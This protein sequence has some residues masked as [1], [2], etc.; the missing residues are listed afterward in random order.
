MD[1]RTYR[2][3]EQ[4][5]TWHLNEILENGKQMKWSLT[6]QKG[7]NY[8]FRLC[9]R[10]FW[11]L[12]GPTDSREVQDLN[13]L[14]RKRFGTL[15]WKQ[16]PL[17]ESLPILSW[18]LMFLP[19]AHGHKTEMCIVPVNNL[20]VVLQST[21]PIECSTILNYSSSSKFFYSSYALI[22]RCNVISYMPCMVCFF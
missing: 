13:A 4:Q 11:H 8:N 1:T 12:I 16:E 5:Q 3:E 10:K 7:V 19:H 9:H 17:F 15:V 2:T 21:F 22:L 14:L 20:P 6:Y 18:D